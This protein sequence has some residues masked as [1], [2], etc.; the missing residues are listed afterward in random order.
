MN[1]FAR[2]VLPQNDTPENRARRQQALAEQ[3]AL[4]R[5]DYHTTTLAGLPMA[6]T[7][8]PIE[9]SLV[10]AA[11]LAEVALG[12]GE[13]LVN[14]VL[15]NVIDFDI[16]ISL[17]VGGAGGVFDT[18]Q[19]PPLA[20]T[21]APDVHGRPNELASG[22]SGLAADAAR[23][24]QDLDDARVALAVA[25][26]KV[27]PST[28]PPAK[29]VPL[30]ALGEA[31]AF[32]G[33]DVA[34]SIEDAIEQRVVSWLHGL[35]QKIEEFL[36]KLFGI[37]G[38]PT[39]LDDYLRQFRTLPLPWPV[40]IYQTDEVFAQL[41]VAGA[42]PLV[43]RRAR[44]EDLVGLALG[45]HGASLEDAL[46]RGALF[47][48][49]YSVLQGLQPGTAPGQKYVFAPRAFFEVTPSGKRSLRPVAIQTSSGAAVVF[50]GDGTP[51]EIA[52]IIVNMADGNYHELISHLGLTHLL[53]EPFVITTYRQLDPEHP[54]HVLLTPHFAGTLF[55]NYAAQTSLITDGGAVDQ[56][57]TGTIASSRQLA[58]KAV[59]AVN[60]NA[61]FL[62]LTLAA[63]GVDDAQDLPDYPY[64]DDALALWHA[65]H[66]WVTA[67][68]Q[69]YYPSAA[70]VIGD[71][72]L[73]AW[74][75]ELA[76]K[77]GG[78]IQGI[79][80]GPADAK[81]RIET[82]EYLAKLLTQVIFTA[83]VQHAAVNFPQRTIM[84]Y[85]PAMPL[86]AYAPFPA[87]QGAPATQI[88][89]LLPPLQMG[90]LQ[91]AVL[92]TLGGVYHTVLGQYGGELAILQV[93]DALRAFQRALQ[94]IE[95][96]IHNKT[97]LGERTPYTTLLPSTIPQSI[98]I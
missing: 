23:F 56:L 42:N 96:D 73:Q 14:I 32:V 21:L 37:Y 57:L 74:V 91:Q 65:I 5:F 9:L 46:R 76:S 35:I 89:D 28:P 90:L 50:P 52:K 55:I 54:L 94:R 22:A 40:G 71:Y 88:L 70:D 85:T 58:A 24:K 26:G 38:R 43:I 16:Q 62:P 93:G 1:P 72:E 47:V 60:Y 34:S 45:D 61:T 97:Q 11:G 92:S 13:N 64:R 19:R 15:P 49:D 83:S 87:K 75:T 29:P 84:A 53:T 8:V 36:G 69:I 67:Y 78:S 80:D 81:P 77:Q 48:T 86:A 25:T 27:L 7:P 41:R 10:W 39:D 12:L 59:M 63:R 95:A 3:Q 2:L 6:A 66:D 31:V 98:N 18:S 68:L 44:A 20:G 51:W 4:Y 79:G 82:V 33:K 30:P 17:K